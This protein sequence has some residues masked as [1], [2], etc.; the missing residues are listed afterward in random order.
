MKHNLCFFYCLE[1]HNFYHIDLLYEVQLGFHYF[2]N[3]RRF[4]A[5]EEGY[6]INIS[7]ITEEC[8]IMYRG[9]DNIRYIAAECDYKAQALCLVQSEFGILFHVIGYC[10][11]LFLNLE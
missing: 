10:I 2:P 3:G 9:I 11:K 8:V 6:E 7:Q 1:M 4:N 5:E